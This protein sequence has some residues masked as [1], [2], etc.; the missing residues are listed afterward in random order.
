[1][2]GSD[3]SNASLA[4]YPARTAP[5]YWLVIGA[6]CF[7]ALIAGGLLV[8]VLAFSSVSVAGHWGLVAVMAAMTLAPLAYW[9]G[10]A[11]YRIGGGRGEIR[12]FAD[13]LEVPRARGRRVQVFPRADLTTEA[14]ELRV[15]YSVV[16]LTAAT[17]KRGFLL[18]LRSGPELRR[19]STLTIPDQRAFLADL[20]RYVNGHAPL[21]RDGHAPKAPPP[22]A[23]TVQEIEDDARLDR[24]LSRV[25]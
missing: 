16:G 22:A 23:K 20:E 18:T 2:A 3:A 24:E 5:G 14:I 11:T 10:T 6:M 4:S 12:F 17:V 7:L 25:D 9:A 8:F 13:R 21:G 1:M 19:L 15:R